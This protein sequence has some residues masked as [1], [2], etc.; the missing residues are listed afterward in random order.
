MITRRNFLRAI[1]ALY[2]CTLAAQPTRRVEKI[3]RVAI[4]GWGTAAQSQAA[5]KAFMDGMRE[6]GW[7][8]GSNIIYDRV[9]AGNDEPR[10]SALAAALVSRGPDLIF[11]SPNVAALAAFEKTRTIPIVF[12]SVSNPVALGLVQ[13]LARPGYNVTGVSNI[14]WQLGGKRFQ[15]LNETL[16]GIARVAVL[17]NPTASDGTAEQELIEKAA[18]EARIAVIPVR[19]RRAD[20]LD[21]ALASLARTRAEALL[22]CHIAFFLNERRRIIEFASRLRIPVV[23]HRTEFA[24]DGAL[25]AYSSL[26][27]D[28][29]R[30]AAHLTDK[31][32]RGV[33][34]ADIPVEQPTRYELAVNLKT[35]TTLGIKIPESVL[36]QALRV[37]E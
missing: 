16:P 27:A 4:L 6:L 18:A 28:Q 21:G 1:P 10:L 30:R 9:H 31:I 12:G 15:L 37:I 5:D 11:V 35:A 25:I 19:A 26:L 17:I 14:G 23:G 33:K 13:S 7:I 2:P 3:V 22:T 36:L 20:E 24:E 8:D 29:Y 34:P 32:L